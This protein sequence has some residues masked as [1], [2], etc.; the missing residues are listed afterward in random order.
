MQQYP[1][2][3]QPSSMGHGVRIGIGIV[4]GIFVIILLSMGACVACGGLLLGV[5]KRAADQAASPTTTSATLPRLGQRT[6]KNGI[7]LTVEKVAKNKTL[8][9]FQAADQNNTYLIVDVLLETLE[10]NEAPYNPLYFKV[11]DSEGIEYNSTINTTQGA[12]SS[13]TLYKGDKVRGKVAF[14]VREKGSGFVLIYEP[15]VIFGGYDAIRI[16][17][18]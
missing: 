14:Q 11:K 18:E 17:L 1:Q 9:R 10:R 7:A 6:E 3:P 15:L 16:Q 8:S 12:L 2:Q 5:S 13:G 4:I